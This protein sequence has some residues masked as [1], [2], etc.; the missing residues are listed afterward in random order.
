MY[1]K[2]MDGLDID[3]GPIN[4]LRDIHQIIKSLR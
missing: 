3:I 4:V 2:D 1:I